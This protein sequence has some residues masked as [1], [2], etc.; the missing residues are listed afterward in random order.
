MSY[1]ELA[2]EIREKP[3]Y[4]ALKDFVNNFQDLKSEES[5]KFGSRHIK[6]T[7]VNFGAPYT[8]EEIELFEKNNCI[9]LPIELKVYLTEISRDLYKK[10]LEFMQIDLKDSP[11]LGKSCLLV[12]NVTPIMR[13]IGRAEDTQYDMEY[14]RK[15][16]PKCIDMDD[17]QLK[18]YIDDELYGTPSQF[19]GFKNDGYVAQD[20]EWCEDIMN[21]LFNGTLELR[22]IGC[23]YTNRIIL[24]GDKKGYVI[25]EQLAGDGPIR[26]DYKSFFTYAVA[27]T[28]L[29]K[30][31]GEVNQNDLMEI[32]MKSMM[33]GGF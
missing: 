19:Q 9:E 21:E 22:E 1:Q 3:I 13:F 12:K 17:D 26:I 33:Y 28:P 2:E 31:Y 7:K 11:H 30:E 10:H 23:G 14:L 25:K 24:N 32:L 5:S 15:N 4:T 27:G 8:L 16:H 6:R 20:M 18:K 29:E